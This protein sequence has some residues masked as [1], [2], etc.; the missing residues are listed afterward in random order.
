[1]ASMAFDAG[2]ELFS[3]KD[4]DVCFDDKNLLGKYVLG[5][6]QKLAIPTVGYSYYKKTRF[7]YY[8]SKILEAEEVRLKDFFIKEMQE[9][10]VEGG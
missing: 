8:I 3:P 1:T 6:D 2:E 7:D 5:S 10:S 9:T 4:G